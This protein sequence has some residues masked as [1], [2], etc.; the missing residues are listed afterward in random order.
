[1]S[2]LADS[3]FCDTPVWEIALIQNCHLNISIVDRLHVVWPVVI[4]SL[5]ALHREFFFFLIKLKISGKITH[6]HFFFFPV[7]LCLPLSLSNVHILTYI[8]SK[9]PQ[10]SCKYIWKQNTE[11]G[12]KSNQT[13]AEE[14]GNKSEVYPYPFCAP[15]QHDD[16]SGITLPTHA[17]KVI[18]C[19]WERPLAYDEFPQRIVALERLVLLIFHVTKEW[20]ISYFHFYL[21]F[22]DFFSL[23]NLYLVSLAITNICFV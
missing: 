16:G 12:D 7:S 9:H 14:K 2:Y 1:M 13:Y 15:C 3:E 8:Y 5:T 21:I 19:R 20:S 11:K 17:P 10:I 4:T 22:Y 6:T 18:P 23:I